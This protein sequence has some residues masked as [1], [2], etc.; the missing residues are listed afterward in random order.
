MTSTAATPLYL[1]VQ[2]SVVFAKQQAVVC[3]IALFA[4]PNWESLTP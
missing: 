4:I 3:D 1:F 2:A